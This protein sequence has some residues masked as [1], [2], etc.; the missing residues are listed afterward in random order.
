MVAYLTL[1]CYTLLHPQSHSLMVSTVSGVRDLHE[2]QALAVCARCGSDG[3]CMRG[4]TGIYLSLGWTQK[5]VIVIR[6]DQPLVS[7]GPGLA[8]R[9][10][11][12][13]TSVLWEP[14]CNRV[15]WARRLFCVCVCVCV[16]VC[17]HTSRSRDAE[18]RPTQWRPCPST[19]DIRRPSPCCWYSPSPWA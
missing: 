12:L 7:A 14:I 9:T 2:V 19:C 13:R 6:M 5:M 4:R 10:P 1:C 15:M 3:R 16:C 11:G 17:A 8:R 18:C